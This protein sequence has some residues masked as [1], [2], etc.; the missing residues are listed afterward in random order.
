MTPRT[1]FES[2]SR[3]NLPTK[4]KAKHFRCDAAIR[5]Q[6][7]S[8]GRGSQDVALYQ[9]QNWSSAA[10]QI[11]ILLHQFWIRFCTAFICSY[12]R[13]SSSFSSV[14][15][16]WFFGSFI[17][18]GSLPDTSQ[19]E[20]LE[21]LD[22]AGKNPRKVKMEELHEDG[23]PELVRTVAL[24]ENWWFDKPVIQHRA[25]LN[26]VLSTLWFELVQCQGFGEQLQSGKGKESFR[27]FQMGYLVL[28]PKCCDKHAQWWWIIQFASLRLPPP[29]DIQDTWSTCPWRS[30]RRWGWRAL[31]SADSTM[32]HRTHQCLDRCL[33]KRRWF[34]R[35]CQ[36]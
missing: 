29:L 20:F 16:W 30:F 11:K 15:P 25:K 33:E 35:V 22:N 5:Y 10:V 23:D 27:R 9:G 34:E 36:A 14:K 2:A 31:P 24:I 7:F 12:R 18:A 19:E 8:G 21:L 17:Y 28:R 6:T 26:Q 4:A 13:E 1:S 3:I 32:D